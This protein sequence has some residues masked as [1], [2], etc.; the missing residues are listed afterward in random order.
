MHSWPHGKPSMTRG[1][2]N[3][4]I[5]HVSMFTGKVI[6]YLK[7]IQEFFFKNPKKNIREFGCALGG[8][9]E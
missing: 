9:N 8:L 1:P 7:K 2:L 6:E 3:W 4:F 5:I